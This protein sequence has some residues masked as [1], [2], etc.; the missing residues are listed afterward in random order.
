MTELRKR[1][2]M[3]TVAGVIGFGGAAQSLRAQE[4]PAAAASQPV[5]KAQ[6]PKALEHEMEAVEKAYRALKR[7]VKD[8][9]KTD[10]ALAQVSAMQQHTLIAKDMVP[11]MAASKPEA[12]RAQFIAKYRAAMGNVL[13]QELLL[14]EQ[15]L[16]GQ[17]E[18]AL[19]TYE[20]LKKLEA[21]GHRE[22]KPKEH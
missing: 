14:E 2:L 11:A 7:L 6:D 3:L 21:D 9:K 5:A 15:I 13:K 19:E 20:S 1:A 12:E 17:T 8:P 18:K 22:F 4:A 16:A 10:A